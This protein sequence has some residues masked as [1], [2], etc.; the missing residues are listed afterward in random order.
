MSLSDKNYNHLFDE[1]IETL[2]DEVFLYKQLLEILQKKQQA[3]LMGDV[4][5]LREC[6]LEENLSVQKIR[7]VAD[8]RKDNIH[9]LGQ[10]NKSLNEEPRL[11]TIINI[12]PLKYSLEFE[13]LRV[14][15]KTNLNQIDKINRENSYVLNA[16]IEHVRNLVN[17][18]LQVDKETS[19][20]Y[21]IEGII[22]FPEENNKVL[23]FQI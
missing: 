13:N 10:F 15:L 4:D 23:D 19:R 8:K 7:S 2:S 3:I 9:K 11:N 17:L 14:R 5:K 16:S 1:L 21:D 12:A 6:V 18:F 20:L 22:S